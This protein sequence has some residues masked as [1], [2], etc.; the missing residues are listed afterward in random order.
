MPVVLPVIALCDSASS[1]N[2][3]SAQFVQDMENLSS[4]T[5]KYTRRS[6]R[7]NGNEAAR[8]NIRWS[9]EKLGQFA[10]E[11]TF[12]IEPKAHF[13]M[14]FGCGYNTNHLPTKNP[15][16][17]PRKCTRR[18]RK[19]V[20]KDRP[21][22]EKGAESLRRGIENGTL[23]PLKIMPPVSEHGDTFRSIAD[24][25]VELDY[26]WRSYSFTDQL[27][28]S[29]SMDDEDSSYV[30]SS[31]H[32]LLSSLEMLNSEPETNEHNLAKSMNTSVSEGPS[33]KHG[34]SHHL[35]Q[36]LGASQQL[37]RLG[38]WMHQTSSEEPQPWVPEIAQPVGAR[39]SFRRCLGLTERQRLLLAETRAATEEA[40]TEYWTWDE[41]AKNYK[42]YD[43]G[44]SE[45][46]WYNPP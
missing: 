32:Q 3:V 15:M 25:E 6:E 19:H 26:V 45:P 12:F 40:S 16:H 39:F 29:D 9:C 22:P 46:V 24:L 20:E 4:T 5:F 44:C 11:G 28:T 2:W 34:L 1:T 31:S 21:L 42:H 43:E 35:K 13:K 38:K 17:F 8:I 7:R 36:D 23:L 41:E 27:L 37:W 33:R 10:E 14:L 30:P 18:R